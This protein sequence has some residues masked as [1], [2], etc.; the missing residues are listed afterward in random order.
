MINKERP[1]E[2]IIRNLLVF[3]FIIICQKT[4]A[5]LDSR[6]MNAVYS[7]RFQ[8]AINYAQEDL[9]EVLALSKNAPAVHARKLAW[10]YF[11]MGYCYSTME[12][13]WPKAEENFILGIKTLSNYYGP[14]DS[15]IALFSYELG[16]LYTKEFR[17]IEAERIMKQAL[18][19]F[20]STGA[21]AMFHA[22]CIEDLGT[23]Y[24]N[25]TNYDAALAAYFKALSLY[26]KYNNDSVI[27]L[28][29]I[30]L[31]YAYKNDPLAESFLRM[32]VEIIQKKERRTKLDSLKLA[33]S[34]NYLAL[35]YSSIKQAP[36]SAV[37]YQS[38][39]LTLHERLYTRESLTYCNA[40]AS[41]GI[42][43]TFSQRDYVKG[44]NTLAEARKIASHLMDTLGVRYNAEFSSHLADAY[45]LNKDLSHAKPLYNTV[46]HNLK[47]IIASNFS[48]L[49]DKEQEG[50]LNHYKYI[51]DRYGA[52]TAEYNNADPEL[53]GELFNIQL[54]T[55]NSLFK[56][57][58]RIRKKYL[59][60]SE[61]QV[62]DLYNK[63]IGNRAVLGK[64]I[65][66]QCIA[67]GDSIDNDNQQIEKKLLSICAYDKDD[68]R[69]GPTWIDIQ[70]KL[71]PS[72]AVVQIIRI[73]KLDLDAPFTSIYAAL[74]LKPGPTDIPVFIEL[75]NADSFEQRYYYDWKISRI[76]GNDISSYS[77]LWEKIS[78]NIKGI[79]KVYV[80]PDGVFSKIN[81]N[82]ILNPITNKYLI[83]EIDIKYLLSPIE[84]YELDAGNTILKSISKKNIVIIGKPTYGASSNISGLGSC[85]T[86]QKAKFQTF[87]SEIN[88]VD[89]LLKSGFCNVKVYSSDSASE[90]TLRNLKGPAILHIS[91]HGF[92]TGSDSIKRR[93]EV[94]A[95]A[96]N[97]LSRKPAR[98]PLYQS[99]IALSFANKSASISDGM[100]DGILNAYEAMN[101]NL[102]S[103]QL[104]VLS[105]CSVG[106]GEMVSGQG[107]F[108][109]QKAFKIAGARNI[110]LSLWEVF[111]KYTR[112]F[113]TQFYSKL[114]ETSDIDDS[115]LFA[116]RSLKS[117][118]NIPPA[119]WGSFILIK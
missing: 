65:S 113:F 62:N 23:I 28:S 26:G 36:D 66:T 81:L 45:L 102:D 84:L 48:Q 32:P 54:F 90:F 8:D 82:T 10:C 29:N 40:L 92:F 61:K 105:A 94:F 33:N 109:F 37:I 64:Y 76:N 101:L 114:L 70:K 115:F 77:H 56:N 35:Y 78:E 112:K 5:Q 100:N 42:S 88:S 117:D 75:G 43:Y 13:Y 39:L 68:N 119:F 57:N 67:K 91:T 49:T 41:L 50:F 44:I 60:C 72:E 86:N 69:T 73:K 53:A 59:S 34:I 111:P 19:I 12:A 104:L 21:W 11:D 103:T 15:N 20:Q 106:D 116:Q 46:T 108:G 80:S 55:K 27:T 58:E 95:S 4:L 97:I 118:P 93:D 14:K 96:N 51:F 18:D 7:Q 83:D 24:L 9:N 30:G 110:I 98:N 74:I 99:G 6:A 2:L 87:D 16:L 17:T 71:K 22:N 3:L 25:Q 89:S 31:V 1:K 38:K 107:L 52:L 85:A 47:N 79:T 63:W